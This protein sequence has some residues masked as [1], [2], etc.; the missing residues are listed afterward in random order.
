MLNIAKQGINGSRERE[1]VWALEAWAMGSFISLG[2][3]RGNGVT[4]ATGALR[5]RAWRRGE[6]I[7]GI[8]FVD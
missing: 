5:R 1:I 2:E 4:R 6:E 7:V 8:R 3:E